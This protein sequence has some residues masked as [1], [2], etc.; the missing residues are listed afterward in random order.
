MMHG[1]VDQIIKFIDFTLEFSSNMHGNTHFKV[2]PKKGQ[3]NMGKQAR[4]QQACIHNSLCMN[5]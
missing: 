4:N 2:N 3:N 5:M 1:H